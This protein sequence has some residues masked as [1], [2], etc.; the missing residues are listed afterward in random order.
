M[1]TTLNIND[2]PPFSQIYN[3]QEF[4]NL[5]P[6]KQ[7]EVKAK[8]YKAWESTL[9][10]GDHSEVKKT[11]D[12]RYPLGEQHP[13]YKS[14][15]VI[16]ETAKQ[17]PGAFAPGF[18]A[19][20]KGTLRQPV[21]I[22]AKATQA[23]TGG[24][25]WATKWLDSVSSKIKQ[26]RAQ[27][28]V[29]PAFSAGKLT[30]EI[31]AQAPLTML[32]AGRISSTL[33][34]TVAEGALSGAL[35]PTT[36]EESVLGRTAGGALM[37]G[38]LGMLGAARNKAGAI[39]ADTPIDA[40][41]AEMRA[42]E[43]QYPGTNLRA[44]QLH[45]PG[46]AGRAGLGAVEGVVAQ[47]PFAGGR[48]AAA[49]EVAAQEAGFKKFFQETTGYNYDDYVALDAAGAPQLDARRKLVQN[50][51]DTFGKMKQF[52]G[53]KY[54]ARDNMLNQVVRSNPN[55]PDVEMDN[56]Y[57]KAIELDKKYG[58]EYLA[59][60]LDPGLAAK[61][62]GTVDANLFRLSIKDAFELE[63]SLKGIARK[64]TTRAIG[65][66]TSKEALHDMA[67]L[68]KALN[69]DLEKY[70]T[71][72]TVVQPVMDLHKKANAAYAK[73]IV[74]RYNVPQIR[75]IALSRLDNIDPNDIVK[76]FTTRGNLSSTGTIMKTTNLE[77]KQLVKAEALQEI[78]KKS[79][80][81][82]T[83]NADKFIGNISR[84]FG[85]DPRYSNLRAILTPNEKKEFQGLL[86]IYEAGKSAGKNLKALE[87]PTSMGRLSTAAGLSAAAGAGAAI[88]GD[89][90]ESAGGRV[91]RGIGMAGILIGGSKATFWLLSS[92]VGRRLLATASS[93][94]VGTPAWDRLTKQI[95]GFIIGSSVKAATSVS[96]EHAAKRKSKETQSGID[97]L[98]AQ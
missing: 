31:A 81:G 4:M 93:T 38:S 84:I 69:D 27:A 51:K 45:A 46:T 30:G 33:G 86:K 92:N 19:G 57:L 44:S 6:D 9:P 74:P 97:M 39:F 98:L 8:Y 52:V 72:N 59:G 42:L 3:S 7:A 64:T 1:P 17:G 73:H 83:F 5:L 54:E 56:F 65:Q 79:Y 48:K 37:G 89:D 76:V 91:T 41:G 96:Q 67:E 95:E 23:I 28:E 13:L 15:G 16:G 87:S 62:A 90:S 68:S 2:L 63:K 24:A 21:T 49:Q 53:K 58:P 11:F 32:P 43:P 94:K 29:N 12:D 34:R 60:V 82:T 88:S 66:N 25:E 61:V 35:T 20:V 80:D 14:S 75:E 22:A 77:G 78:V 70:T 40:Y 71:Q 26:E 47:V 50:V 85:D 18:I 55:L 36:K 10:D